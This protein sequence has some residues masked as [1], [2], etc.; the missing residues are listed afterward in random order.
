MAL[1]RV[2]AGDG[3]VRPGALAPKGELG[4][5]AG[6]RPGPAGTASA[7]PTR[8]HFRGA[9]TRQLASAAGRTRPTRRRPYWLCWRSC[10]AIAGVPRVPTAIM[11][12][13]WRR[14]MR[15]RA[16]RRA[17]LLTAQRLEGSPLAT[18][19]AGR[20]LAV[21]AGWKPESR[22][23]AL[24]RGAGAA[25]GAGAGRFARGAWRTFPARILRP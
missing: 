14:R 25:G 20:R 17:V 24:A 15:A 10:N 9:G 7:C 3:A 18:E 2:F 4:A 22:G 1:T 21:H 6:R 5:G 11:C 8:R 12:A 16:A 19:L 13:A 23:H